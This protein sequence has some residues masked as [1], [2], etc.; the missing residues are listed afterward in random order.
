[1]DTKKMTIANVNVVFGDSEEPMVY[2]I[3]DIIIP[4]LTSEIYRES[5]KDTRFLFS[6]VSLRVFDGEY[7]LCGLIIKD[8]ILEIQSEY[9]DKMGLIQTDKSMQSA[10]Y[11]LFM[12]YLR[13]HRMVLVKNQKGSPDIR[14][15]RSTFSAVMQKYISKENKRRKEEHEE[16]LLRPKNVAV[17]GIKTRQN[18]KE[19]L[20]DVEKIETVTMRF[21]PLN[22]EWDMNPL[23]G[24]I[25]NVRR[26]LKSKTGKMVF[27]S[28]QDIEAVATCIEKSGGLFE[29]QMKVRYPSNHPAYEQKS[30]KATIKDSQISEDMNID[31]RN[32]LS[33][34][35]DEVYAC[36]NEILSLQ[37]ES[38]NNVIYYEEFLKRRKD[39]NE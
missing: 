30:R 21:F 11:S 3:D 9:D 35:Y 13:N 31:L 28:P 2:H 4:A 33:N 38:K 37:Q 29:T 5:G 25:D 23:I 17:T 20:K 14:S 39:I 26:S 19:V 34:A 7:V 36:K 10:P 15:F 6:D 27:N 32:N 24:E 22:G 16:M 1:M 18:I 8:T 12:I